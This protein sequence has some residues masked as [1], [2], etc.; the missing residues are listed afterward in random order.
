MVAQHQRWKVLVERE[1]QC[2]RRD[3]AAGR[4]TFLDPYA[5]KN[6]AELFAVTTEAFFEMPQAL[7]QSHVEL[8]D[9][10]REF[11]KQDPAGFFKT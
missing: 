9:L 7:Q 2:L 10:F 5:T 11:Y 1:Y 6:K 8:Y 4:Y 3:V